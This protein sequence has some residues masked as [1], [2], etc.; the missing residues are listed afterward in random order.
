MKKVI[1]VIAVVLFIWKCGCSNN[2]NLS[3]PIV[4]SNEW[5]KGGTLHKAK[6][7]DWKSATERNKLATCA[8]FVYLTNKDLSLSEVK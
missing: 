4:E 5:F 7:I 2:S 3:G 6:I 1:I 8:D